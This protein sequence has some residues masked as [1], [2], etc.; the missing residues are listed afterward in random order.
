VPRTCKTAQA[1]LLIP[2]DNDRPIGLT[3]H[4]LHDQPFENLPA[5]WT[6]ED[7]TLDSS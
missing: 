6:L 2:R 1:R 7:I 3:F 4:L 5:H